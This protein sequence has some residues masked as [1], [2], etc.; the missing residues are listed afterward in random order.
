MRLGRRPIQRVTLFAGGPPWSLDVCLRVL[1]SRLGHQ[2]VQIDVLRYLSGGA[3]VRLPVPA[4][5]DPQSRNA[6]SVA[7]RGN[8]LLHPPT[9]GVDHH[10]GRGISVTVLKSPFIPDRANAIWVPERSPQTSVR[11]FSRER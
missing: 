7:E 10:H 2:G 4:P 6:N 9:V 11:L 1:V 3:T 5:A 8:D